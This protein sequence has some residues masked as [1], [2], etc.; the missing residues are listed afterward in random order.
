M[1]SI[2]SFIKSTKV[3]VIISVM[4]L[5]VCVGLYLYQTYSIA[6]GIGFPT[7]DSWGKAALAISFVTSEK[8][9]YKSLTSSLTSP[10]WVAFLAIG[11]PLGDKI[12]LWAYLLGII[13]LALTIFYVYKLSLRI[14]N[15]N[16]PLAFVCAV[17]T[18]LEWRLIF[19]ALSG[20]GTMLFVFLSIF[21][22]YLYLKG[23]EYP[24]LA[25]IVAGVL[26]L[27]R[28]EG[29][30][31]FVAMIIDY[32]YHRFRVRGTFKREVAI[33]IGV[34]FAIV[35]PIIAFNLIIKGHLLPNVFYASFF[36]HEPSSLSQYFLDV[37]RFFS[38]GHLVFLFSFSIFTF[39]AFLDKEFFILP[40]VWFFLLLIAYA[41][42]PNLRY[43]QEQYLAPLLPILIIYAIYSLSH[44]FFSSGIKKV[45]ILL[46]IYCAVV[47]ILRL[48][49]F[50]T[51]SAYLLSIQPL[52][53]VYLIYL[54]K[55]LAV[56][57]KWKARLY[58]VGKYAVFLVAVASIAFFAYFCGKNAKKYAW[59]VATINHQGV[60]MGHWLKE[61]TPS[62][63]IIATNHAGAIGFFSK[64]KVVD[65][66]S[67]LTS[68]KNGEEVIEPLLKR[69][70]S[71]LVISPI[72]YLEASRDIRLTPIHKITFDKKIP[73]GEETIQLVAYK[74]IGK[75]RK[76]PVE[77]EKIVIEHAYFRKLSEFDNGTIHLFLNNRGEK[78]V[79]V[80]K[81]FLDWI[82]FPPS[83]GLGSAFT[84][85]AEQATDETD[86]SRVVWYRVIPNPVPPGCISDV[87]VKCASPDVG[88][89]PTITTPEA[90]RSIGVE[91]NDGQMYSR[92][93]QPVNNP[94]R[95]TYVGFSEDFSF[96][97]IYL[98]NSGKETLRVNGLFLDSRDVTRYSSKPWE[99]LPQGQK[100]CIV[101]KLDKPLRQG[102]YI[103]V[104]AVAEE[105][106]AS[107]AV[108][109]VFSF[110]P[111]NFI[112]SGDIGANLF[113]DQERFDIPYPGDEAS[114][115]V[116]KS[117]AGETKKAYFLLGCPAHAHGTP[118]DAAIKI[119]KRTDICRNADP[120]HPAYIHIC[121]S[122]F[123]KNFFVFG[124]TADIIFTNPHQYLASSDKL[125]EKKEHP[126]Q[127]I[128]AIAKKGC[129]PRPLYT[130]TVVGKDSPYFTS[131][132]PSPE[133]E[134]LLV[135]YEISRGAKGILY[136]AW[137][138]PNPGPPKKELGMEV[139]KISGEL[140]VLKRFLKV[141][142]PVAL[143]EASEKMVEAITILS[144][145][146]AIVLIL[147]NQDVVYLPERDKK[148]FSYKAKHDF[149]VTVHVPE[150]M[151]IKDVYE[152]GGTFQ[153]MKY[154]QNGS[155][156]SIDIDKLYTTRQFVLTT[157]KDDYTF[158]QDEDGI[159]DIREVSIL[160]T[161]PAIPNRDL[162]SSK[163]KALKGSQF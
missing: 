111:I 25:V 21:A 100:R 15:E 97:Y 91:T 52:F 132:F 71:Y 73:S 48:R 135:Y 60:T 123:E 125:L 13:C 32:V 12:P 131:R 50:Y 138:W 6:G 161:H 146:K 37:F 144:G 113:I 80:T 55:S 103:A 162:E 64:R 24:L 101:V 93:I 92:V 77:G 62:D 17:L 157:D 130:V 43:A 53:L 114:A 31:L 141:G 95:I 66:A 140:Q 36:P 89:S 72:W 124:E 76:P 137:G 35:I 83:E 116:W 75:L 28:L 115:S 68:S 154:N 49:G 142:E 61:N 56:D 86:D 121:R 42:F 38:Q 151:N 152:V 109:R 134:R 45:S 102:E 94:L 107:E 33:L 106:I 74:V 63:A 16:I 90:P 163:G 96:V 98:E 143:A 160:G 112:E 4:I 67:L 99:F 108:V 128:T 51:K 82:A 149:T 20:M 120:F 27:I 119:F 156:L 58:K 159:S 22:I 23:R 87:M 147:I 127:W 126:T 11:A 158:D 3:L 40:I 150:W 85:K 133:E 139:K 65:T 10:L 84:V 122:A 30:L 8:L 110:F 47:L 153:K 117:E 1:N 79:T 69:D 26:I 88:L 39:I 118:S 34:Y 155:D 9:P 29:I 59:D 104:K 129:E 41:V 2:T 46:G 81:V 5:L 105:N 78:P 148:P 44:V 54:S 14:F 7:D 19:S 18:A 70:V 145:N 136:R 57:M